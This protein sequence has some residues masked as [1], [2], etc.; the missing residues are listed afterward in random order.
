VLQVEAATC[1]P[2]EKTQV[3]VTY[4]LT[5]DIP[6]IGSATIDLGSTAVMQCGG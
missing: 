2:G 3:R 6:L 1:T 5:Y 4:P